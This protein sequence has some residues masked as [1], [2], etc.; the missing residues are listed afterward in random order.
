MTSSS[1]GASGACGS[2]A[3]GSVGV[4]GGVGSRVM[5]VAVSQM[6]DTVLDCSQAVVM[7]HPFEFVVVSAI[8]LVS[9]PLPI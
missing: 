1:V 6:P 2:V 7:G 3:T 9:A 5:G 4:M 8:D